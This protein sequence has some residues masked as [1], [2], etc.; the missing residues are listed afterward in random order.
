MMAAAPGRRRFWRCGNHAAAWPVERRALPAPGPAAGRW[1]LFSCWPRML[2]MLASALVAR[3]CQGCAWLGHPCPALILG[4]CR[5]PTGDVRAPAPRW[6][7]SR[8]THVTR[9][10][11]GGWRF[12]VVADCIVIDSQG[13]T[14]DEASLTGEADPMK[15]NVHEDPWVRSGTQVRARP[16]W[17]AAEGMDGRPGGAH[18]SAEGGLAPM[19][20]AGRRAEGRGWQ[21]GWMG[22]WAVRLRYRVPVRTHWSAW[23]QRRGEGGAACAA[24]P[25]CRQGLLLPCREHAAGAAPIASPS[26]TFGCV[27]LAAHT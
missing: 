18:S 13:L 4:C 1:R 8:A 21:G 16:G 26:P 3:M 22:C 11:N 12:Q 20:G 10:L 2:A 23:A 15:K 14:M 6:H 24:S 19:G 7:S 27:L 5:S 25:P 9:L 17:P